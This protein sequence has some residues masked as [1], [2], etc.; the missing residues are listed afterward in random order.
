M[1]ILRVLSLFAL[2]KLLQYASRVDRIIFHAGVIAV[3]FPK[4]ILNL[5]HI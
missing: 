1:Y 3:C 4:N 2:M 5:N